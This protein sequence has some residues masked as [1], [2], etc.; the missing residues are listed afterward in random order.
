MTGTFFILPLYLTV[1]D[2]RVLVSGYN[3]NGQLGTGDTVDLHTFTALPLEYFGGHRVTKIA[4]GD[5]HTLCIVG[6]HI[7]SPYSPSESGE[8]YAWGHNRSGQLGLGDTTNRP[9]PCRVDSL[10]SER[11][12][13]IGAGW[14]HSICVTG[15]PSIPH[16]QQHT[17]YTLGEIMSMEK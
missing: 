3:S 2:G 11:V 8:V 17:K 13:E 5:Y 7:L 1:E 12:I 6:S 10:T 4:C 15:T 9:K 16:P 14:S